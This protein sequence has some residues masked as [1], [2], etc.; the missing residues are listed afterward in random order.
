MKGN[1]CF[2]LIDSIVVYFFFFVFSDIF[3]T[4]VSWLDDLPQLLKRL[5]NTNLETSSLIFEVLGHAAA[6]KMLLTLDKV[7]EQLFSELMFSFTERCMIIL[8][9]V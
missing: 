6:K 8:A 4:L 3:T 5:G 7:A 2:Q 9:T 1:L